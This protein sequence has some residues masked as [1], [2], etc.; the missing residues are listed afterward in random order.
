M[1][2]RTL[3]LRMLSFTELS[4][5]RNGSALPN[6]LPQTVEQRSPADALRAPLTASVNR[7]PQSFLLGR[8][9]SGFTT[10]RKI[11]PLRWSPRDRFLAMLCDA[12]RATTLRV[13]DAAC[14]SV[15]GSEKVSADSVGS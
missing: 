10:S 15:K 9:R 5:D 1:S 4:T 11:N 3:A 13:S 12:V 6:R 8:L 14:A 7:Y 2:K